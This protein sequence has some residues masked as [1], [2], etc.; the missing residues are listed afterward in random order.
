MPMRLRS[1]QVSIEAK[2]EAMIALI[3]G[4]K[5][6][7]KAGQD[8]LNRKIIADQNRLKTQMEAGQDKLKT[9]T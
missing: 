9:K 2:L 6:E 7:M 1:Q 5:T 8:K 4:L 3:A